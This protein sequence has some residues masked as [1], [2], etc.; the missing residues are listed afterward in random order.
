MTLNFKKFLLMTLVMSILLLSSGYV[1]AFS[2]EEILTNSS[3]ENSISGPDLLLIMM[4]ILVAKLSLKINA[5]L[6]ILL[7]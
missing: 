6:I 1:S 2:D 7:I 5:L 3:L 4:K